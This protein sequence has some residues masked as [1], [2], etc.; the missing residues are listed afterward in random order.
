[1]LHIASTIIAGS[2]IIAGLGAP[3]SVFELTQPGHF[4]NKYYQELHPSP[5]ELAQM[6]AS[7]TPHVPTTPK[8]D[9]AEAPMI[10]IPPA[11]I[12]GLPPQ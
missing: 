11:Y 6:N 8:S 9:I 1:M 3:I 7:M 12:E 4:V 5:I 2:I 10:L